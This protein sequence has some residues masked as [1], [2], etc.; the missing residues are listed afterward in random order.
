MIDGLFA[1]LLAG[2]AAIWY[3]R[4]RYDGQG[5]K[6]DLF[7][8]IGV[9]ALLY[10]SLIWSWGFYVVP[11]GWVSVVT[12]SAALGFVSILYGMWKVTDWNYIQGDKGA[13]IQEKG[14]AGFL[15]P[16]IFPCRTT[17]TRLFPRKHSFSYSY[18]YVGIPIGWQ[19]SVKTF[20]SADIEALTC[21]NNDRGER[22]RR[23]K[24]AW[25]SV[26]GRDYLNRGGARLGLHGKL[27]E[28]LVSQARS[29]LP[30][31]SVL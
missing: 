23:E 14:S 5:A 27:H 8:L 12:C 3:M 24:T 1:A 10:R 31:I 4:F 13:A 17:H 28:Y 11:Q 18:L 2:N 15:K 20:L 9:Y 21:A 16:L 22:P 29:F 19:G 7:L 26:E 25:L 30:Y 6:N